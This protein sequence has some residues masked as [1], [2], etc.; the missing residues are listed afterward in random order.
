VAVLFGVCAE[1]SGAQ[2][3]DGTP[4][5]CNRPAA[6]SDPARSVAVLYFDNLSRDSSDAYLADGLTDE[7]IARLGRVRRLVVA[8]RFSVR[9]YRNSEAEPSAVGRALG[10][11]YLVTGSVQRAG[12]RLRVRVELLRAAS[13]VR[14]WGDEFDRTD[15]DVLAIQD[16][17]A[18]RIAT[19]IAGTLVP[20]ER[21]SLR[22]NTTRNATAFAHFLRGE[23]YLARRSDVGFA[24]AIQQYDSAIRL[25]PR[26]AAAHARIGLAYA[27]SL[28]LGLRPELPA[29]TLLARGFAATDRAL[30]LDSSSPDAWMA[31]GFLLAG[32][33]TVVV[34]DVRAAFARALAADPRNAEAHHIFGGALRLMGF[35]SEAEAEFRQALRLEPA[36]PVTLRLLAEVAAV[37]RRLADARRYLDSAVASDPGFFAAYADRAHVRAVT[38]DLAGARGD[39]E[40]ALRI[41]QGIENVWGRAV[42]AQLNAR[43]G[44]TTAA[45]SMLAALRN[46]LLAVR[47]GQRHWLIA[48]GYAV[49]GD[50]AMVV[51]VLERIEPRSHAWFFTQMPDFDGMRDNPAFR[52]FVAESR[53]TP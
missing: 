48:A 40:T 42:L 9:R 3:P 51:D 53:P 28:A 20:A 2:C 44:D 19:A 31:R 52:R 27:L 35:A 18:Q 5:P 21:D 30:L 8:S 29:D 23:Y 7:T 46:E 41:S 24:S 43:S 15:A 11:A 4:P 45:R 47:G 17:V 1:P 49:L 50:T 13:G 12:T 34:A 37:Q 38:G 16:E 25:D 33:S 10:V 36:R 14:V 32:R 26:F 22:S 6:R 39:A